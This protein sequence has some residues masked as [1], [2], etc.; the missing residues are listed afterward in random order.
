MS[1][2]SVPNPRVTEE[3]IDELLALTLDSDPKARS[4]AVR[5]LCPCHVRGHNDRIW[6]RIFEMVDDDDLTVRRSVFHALG[7]GSPRALERKVVAAFE[8]MTRDPDERLARR[9]RQ[10]LAQYRRTGKVNIL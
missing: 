10:M 9:A 1:K 7:D 2:Y 3:D 5:G 6:E 8:T 4:R